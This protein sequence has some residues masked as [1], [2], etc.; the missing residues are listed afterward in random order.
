MRQ[1]R[2]CVITNTGYKLQSIFALAG[3]ERVKKDS[4]SPKSFEPE[5]APA[6]GGGDAAGGRLSAAQ[7][8]AAVA[9]RL[10]TVM[11]GK[12]GVRLQVCGADLQTCGNNHKRVGTMIDVVPR[13]CHACLATGRAARPACAC[14]CDSKVFQYQYKPHV[15][16]VDLLQ[17]GCSVFGRLIMSPQR[18]QVPEPNVLI[19][20][21]R[22]PIAT[23]LP[24]TW[25][26][27]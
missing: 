14:R 1:R 26:P 3:A 7:A 8:R 22:L 10:L 12:T 11:N 21:W 2:P 5:A 16:M 4:P 17:P 15:H 18:L 25:L 24:S 20:P 23:R 27:C 6:A 13:W 9:V 19:H